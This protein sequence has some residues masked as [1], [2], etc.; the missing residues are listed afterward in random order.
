MRTIAIQYLIIDSKDKAVNITSNVMFY[1]VFILLGALFLSHQT[2]ATKTSAQANGVLGTSFDI[3]LYGIDQTQSHATI[4]SLLSHIN[5]LED[6]LSTWRKDSELS[7][8]NRLKQLNGMSEHLVQVLNLCHQWEIQS[9]QHF[10]CR[11]GKIHKQWQQAVAKQVLPNRIAMRRLARD[12]IKTPTID[13]NTQQ[14]AT[15]QSHVV[16][17]VSA[18][19]KGYIL[20]DAI[21][22]IR[23]HSPKVTGIKLNIGGDIV[24][25]GEKQ[26]NT[27]WNTAISQHNVMN[28]NGQATTISISQGAIAHSGIGERDF[29]I[30]R[31]QFSHIL[32]PKEG[33]PIDTPHSVSVYAMNATTADA[34]ATM[35]SNMDIASAI[36]WVNEQQ[37][38]EALFQTADGQK[39]WSNNWQALVKTESNRPLTR[40]T[41]DYQIPSFSDTDYER[42]YLAIWLTDENNQLVRQLLLLGSSNRWAQENKRWWRNVGRKNDSMLD[43]LAKPT[44]RPG[45]YNVQ[46]DG[47]DLH[48]SIVEQEQ[49]IVHVEASRE[50]GGHDYKRIKIDLTT[51]SPIV[52]NGSGE[53]GKTVITIN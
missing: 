26:P 25:W 23:T 12:I 5:D 3:T 42:P 51:N 31:R 34:T 28:D 39:Y 27:Q 22:F 6:T 30:N 47:F 32:A 19:A 45:H 20:D 48:H 11:M 15:I 41:V 16:Y 13:F 49:L 53:I 10:S 38:L 40:L 52:L 46:W 17:D 37:D 36:D 8:L 14:T 4:S 50:H 7:Q 29:K 33:W 2:F 43:A 9:K 18:L 24:F 1:R 21:K 35:L 44:R